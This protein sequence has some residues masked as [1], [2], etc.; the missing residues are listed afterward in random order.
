MQ[1]LAP[2]QFNVQQTLKEK[3]LEE[4]A[5]S[6]QFQEQMRAWA[7]RKTG[8]GIQSSGKK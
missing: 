6:A 4:Q 7:A 8:V 5:K 3:E 2:Q 1:Q